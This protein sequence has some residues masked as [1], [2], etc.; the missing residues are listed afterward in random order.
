MVQGGDP[1]GNGTSGPG[2]RVTDPPPPNFHY[3][4]GTVAMG[5]RASE[6]VGRAGSDFFIVLGLGWTIRPEYAV[7]GQVGAGIRT[8]KRIGSLGTEAE[9]PSRVIK[10]EAIRIRRR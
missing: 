10:I 9:T 4:L 6:P 2:Y 7:I 5:K 8:V 1:R 3:R